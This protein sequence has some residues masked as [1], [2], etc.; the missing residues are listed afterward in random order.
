MAGYCVFES[1]MEETVKARRALEA[2][3]RQA[4]ARREFALVYQPQFDLL[5]RRVTGFEAL[6][7]WNSPTR[8]PVSPMAF[9][10]LAEE[11]GIINQIGEWVLRTA[12]REAANWPDHITVAVNVSA[13][14]LANRAMTT[15]VMSALADSGLDPRQLELEITESVMLDAHG[16]ALGVLQHLRAMGVRVS[17]DDFGTGYSSLGYLRS[18]P[19]DKIKIDQSFV[20]RGSEDPGDRAI[21][22]AIASLGHNLGMPTVAEGVETTEQMERV[23]ADG[24][25]YVQGYLLSR[26]IAPEQIDGFLAGSVALEL[27]SAPLQPV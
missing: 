13:V 25:T 26:P 22:R 4:V 3:L 23:T 7:R 8:G 18:F 12:C 21:V 10:P 1:G 27:S 5:N 11:T 2:D 6:L 16:T 9:I 15:V 20:R 19:F 17:L 14:Q 24:C